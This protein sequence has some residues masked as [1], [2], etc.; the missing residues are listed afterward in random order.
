MKQG[1]VIQPLRVTMMLAVFVAGLLLT[2]IPALAQV[3]ANPDGVAVTIGNRT[4]K[5]SIPAVEF[6]HRDAEAMKR[7][8]A[9]TLGFREGNV[10]DLRDAT[11]TQM[12][13]VFGSERSHRGRLFQIVRSKESDVVVFYSGHG[14]PGL[15]DRRGYLLPVDAELRTAEIDG[16][17]LDLLYANLAKSEARSVTVYLDACFSG[18][19]AG[20]VLLPNVSG[21]MV[22]PRLPAAAGGLTVMAAARGDQVAS[23]DAEAKHGLFT[24]HLLEALRG[25]ADAAPYGNGDG[26]V[27]AAEAKAYLDREMTYAA[28]RAYGREQNAE[29]TGAGERVLASLPPLDVSGLIPLPSAPALDPVEKEL[30]AAQNARVRAEPN[31]GAAIVTTLPAG[32]RIHVAGKVSGS[33][34]Y[35]VERDG[36]RLGYVFGDLLQAAAV[37]PPPPVPP[38]PVQP[39][40]GVFPPPQVLRPGQSFK[41]TFPG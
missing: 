18:E 12:E 8:V 22:T 37:A 1:I 30:V 34:W 38:S 35:L 7:F 41:L 26:K 11:K 31:A 36:R 39:A 28:R 19:S 33:N 4:Y 23:W 9:G 21:L 40:V 17:P 27:T 24:R 20:G 2:N 15:R 16:F 5:G 29:L 13:Q 14:V 6:A 3:P 10:I 25:K 32:T